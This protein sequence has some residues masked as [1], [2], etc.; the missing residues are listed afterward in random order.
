MDMPVDNAGQSVLVDNSIL[1]NRSK[2]VGVNLEL[3]SI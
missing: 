2:A 3:L 1:R